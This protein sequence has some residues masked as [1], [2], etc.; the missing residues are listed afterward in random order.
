MVKVHLSLCWVSY[1]LY[2]YTIHQHVLSLYMLCAQVS[3]KGFQALALGSHCLGLN[4]SFSTFY[5]SDFEQFIQSLWTLVSSSVTQYDTK[6]FLFIWV[7]ARIKKKNE[8]A[9]VPCWDRC[10]ER[11]SL[12]QALEENEQIEVMWPGWGDVTDNFRVGGH[13]WGGDVRAL[14]SWYKATCHAEIWG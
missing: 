3:W 7:V 9:H 13:C 6:S 2:D 1:S 14:S 11:E 12:R 10:L 8:L 5:W 4:Y